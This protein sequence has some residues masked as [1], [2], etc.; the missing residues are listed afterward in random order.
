MQLGQNGE[1]VRIVKILLAASMLLVA[2]IAID[3][4]VLKARRIKPQAL[5]ADSKM[6]CAAPV[7]RPRRQ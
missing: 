5:K 2:L 6:H 1:T 3:A 7:K 4:S